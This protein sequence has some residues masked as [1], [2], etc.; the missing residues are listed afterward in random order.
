M[1]NLLFALAT[2]Y[3]GRGFDFL[4]SAVGSRALLLLFKANDHST[5]ARR[6][7]MTVDERFLTRSVV[8]ARFPGWVKF[9]AL[10]QR[11]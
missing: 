9:P 11:A 2:T 5:V 3:V 8:R 6:V 1:S 10:C 7:E 4:K